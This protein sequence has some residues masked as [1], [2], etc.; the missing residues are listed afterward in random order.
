MT[1]LVPVFDD[2]P[3]R[4]I[5]DTAFALVGITSGE[6]LL[7]KAVAVPEQ[8]PL[9]LPD[10]ILASHRSQLDTT[11]AELPE[12]EIPTRGVVRVGHTVERIVTTAV[13]EHGGSVIVLEQSEP[14]TDSS[15]RPLRSS[16]VET[17]G[18]G[19]DC[20]VVVG[21]EAVDYDGVSSI[22]VP[23]AEGP[24]TMRAVRVAARVAAYHDAAVELLHVVSEGASD[25]GVADGRDLLSTATDAVEW[26][27]HAD[28]WLLE[29][30]DVAETIIEQ[31][32]YYDVTVIGAP[33]KGR[34]RQ[35]I[36]GST[37]ADVERGAD[38]TVLTVRKNRDED[39]VVRRWL[40]P[41]T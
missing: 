31:S 12:A 21:T 27:V 13:A 16:P 15:Y 38:N 17:I 33:Q 18:T 41:G 37:T 23:V 35:F 1:V 24:H 10:R 32:V 34:L 5:L 20:D 30:D 2:T 4:H 3:S 26:E 11:L 14:T 28:T 6:L 22:L 8:T 25:E 39:T 36:S 29:N 7:V 19:A 9:E 40:G